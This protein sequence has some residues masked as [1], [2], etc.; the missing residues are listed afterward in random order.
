MEHQF[1]IVDVP[2]TNVNELLGFPVG[3]RWKLLTPS[4]TPAQEP[5]NMFDF[6]APPD[7]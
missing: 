5:I 7:T 2:V 3:S 1:P 4:V 6:Q